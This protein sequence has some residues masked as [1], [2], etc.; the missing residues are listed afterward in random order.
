MPEVS[1]RHVEKR[2][3]ARAVLR[4]FSLTVHDSEFFTLVGPSGCGKSTLLQL[5]AGLEPLTSGE[6]YFGDRRVTHLSPKERDVAMVF[7]SYALYP[8]KTV[9]ENLAFPLRVRKSPGA[10]IQ[11][12]VRRVAGLLGIEG[13]LAKKP[14]EIS[15]GE[16][17]RVALGRALIREPVVFLMD[18]PLSN[19]DAH[20]RAQTRSEIRRLHMRLKTTM[21]YVTHDQEEALSLS[22]RIAV[23]KA[24]VLQQVATPQEI[25]RRPA[26]TFVAQF[27][28]SPSINLMRARIVHAGQP[29]LDLGAIQIPVLPEEGPGAAPVPGDVL[30]GLRP[31]DVQV[32][33][34]ATDPALTASV[35]AAEPAGARVWV[36][37]DWRGQRIRAMAPGDFQ[38]ALDQPVGLAI[39]PGRWHLFDAR[40]SERLSWTVA[41]VS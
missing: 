26:N 24:G 33:A 16:R 27:I 21:L 36:D 10:Q 6:I 18:E 2:Y 9:F 37:L 38:A 20:L 12:E 29:A 34:Q 3:G 30:A 11:N 7:Q 39:A 17:Q 8:H 22:D 25:Y 13:L 32:M 23:L 40:S 5:V 14:A 35:V 15:G 41:S 31:E 1:F 28:G 4:D 19:L